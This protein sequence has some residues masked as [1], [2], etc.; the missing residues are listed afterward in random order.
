MNAGSAEIGVVTL[1][2]EI[3]LVCCVVH[4]FEVVSCFE[5]NRLSD[6]DARLLGVGINKV[7]GELRHLELQS[8]VETGRKVISAQ[9]TQDIFRCIGH[10]RPKATARRA[11]RLAR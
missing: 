11:L 3:R 9:V 1:L 10:V 2:R 4:R 6:S 5:I 7:L 8:G